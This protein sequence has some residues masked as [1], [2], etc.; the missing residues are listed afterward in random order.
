MTRNISRNVAGRLTSLSKSSRP[1]RP[2]GTRRGSMLPQQRWGY[3][4][5]RVP[6]GCP[7][8]RAL[9]AQ[10]PSTSTSTDVWPLPAPWP[11]AASLAVQSRSNP[12][13]VLRSA[14]LRRALWNPQSG[15][16][17]ETGW[18]GRKAAGLKPGLMV[19]LQAC[20]ALPPTETRLADRGDTPEGRPARC[21]RRTELGC[22]ISCVASRQTRR[23]TG[24]RPSSYD[25]VSDR[26]K[27]R[28]D[29]GVV[30]AW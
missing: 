8:A 13:P 26:L 12:A 10:E 21:S 4:V 28:G 2:A 19:P 25:C 5:V 20:R 22:K 9:G 30:A 15:I 24:G 17:Q 18:A 1:A 27:K 16:D 11:L 7:A 29:N 14:S 3:P 6:R 23:T